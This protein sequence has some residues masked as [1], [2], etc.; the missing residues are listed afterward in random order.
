M[1][2]EAEPGAASAGNAMPAYDVAHY[3]S[4][5]H[6]SSVSRLRKAFAPEDFAQLFRPSGQVGLFDRPLATMQPLWIR[7]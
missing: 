7:T 6:T 3:L 5:L 2:A 1:E 4:V